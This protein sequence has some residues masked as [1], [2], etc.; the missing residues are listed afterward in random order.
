MKTIEPNTAEIIEPNLGGTFICSTSPI[1]DGEG[2]LTGYTHTLKD[3]TESKQLEAQLQQAQKMEA[4]GTLAGGIAHDFNNLLMG[5]Q[6]NV[7]LMLMDMDSTHPYYERLKNI[8][9]QVQSGARL[10]SHL[11]GYARKGKYEVK[12]VN[13]NH[14]VKEI[15]ETFGRTR[16]GITI[17]R[18]LAEDLFAIKADTGQIEQVLLNL[19]VN[20]ADAMP[21][22]GDLVLKTMNVTHKD[23][24]GK[25]YDPK[26]GKYILLT[27]TD[28]GVGMDKK[29]MER[30]F[31][32]FF[33]TKEMGRGTG[34]GLAS[35][36][37]IIKGHGGYIDVASKKGH[38]TTF[39]M[40]LPASEKKVQE[41]V[42]TAEEVIE[43]TGTVLLTDDEEAILEVGQELLEAMGY[44]VLI[45]RNGNEAIE[46]YDKNRDEIEIVVLDMVMPRMGGGEA[47]DRM[48]EINPDIK[49]LL[50]SGFSIDGEATEILARGCDG[51]IQKPF[52]IK[53]LSQ[54]IKEALEQ[55]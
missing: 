26:P 16:K 31:D 35:A 23:M 38:G 41:V 21:S 22:G 36:Y 30:V 5:V 25:L 15:S 54:A 37:G 17:H 7:H 19:F 50:S 51:F 14:L 43:G 32:P 46:V 11:L 27:V 42:K 48:K 12:P 40:Y 4:I 45:A 39:A 29:T 53:E 49:V 55:K 6:G 10:T 18:K 20:A 47:Y 9:K 13:L 2:K 33:T 24:K 44:R 34:L 8:A 3:I 1:L 52:T 28:T